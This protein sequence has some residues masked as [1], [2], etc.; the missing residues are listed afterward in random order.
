MNKRIFL[1][2]GRKP[3]V[4]PLQPGGP[5]TLNSGCSTPRRA[6]I[7]L[8]DESPVA[9]GLLTRPLDVGGTGRCQLFK[10]FC[11]LKDLFRKDN[12]IR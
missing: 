8:A 2:Q 6:S 3:C 12:I 5:V 4:Q 11:G 10:R 7:T 1:G 9:V